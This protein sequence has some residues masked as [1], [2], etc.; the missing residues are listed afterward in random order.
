MLAYI[1][2]EAWGAC[3]CVGWL[4]VLRHSEDGRRY[5]VHARHGVVRHFG[6]LAVNG[7]DADAG[8][9]CR[10]SRANTAPGARAPPPTGG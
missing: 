7:I 8:E 6:W 4:F 9:P 3:N 2:L 1:P 5:G 10:Y